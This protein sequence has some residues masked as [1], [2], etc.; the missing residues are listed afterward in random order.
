MST[1]PY[2][3]S[4]EAEAF[5]SDMSAFNIKA[6][7]GLVVPNPPEINQ[8]KTVCAGAALSR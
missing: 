5:I 6:R 4:H 8:E 2:M 3:G 1:L 7:R